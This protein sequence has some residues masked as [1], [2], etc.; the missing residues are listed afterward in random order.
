MRRYFIPPKRHTAVR[1]RAY[2]SGLIV[3]FLLLRPLISL[4]QMEV[5]RR[6]YREAESVY[7]TN[8]LRAADSY[9]KAQKAALQVG[10]VDYAISMS[11][12]LA[13]LYYEH[14]DDYPMAILEARRG[15]VWIARSGS[16]AD[17]TLFKLWA[18]LGEMYH[19][20]I[21]LDSTRYFWQQAE[22]I[23]A[24]H[25]ELEAQMHAHS[26]AYYGNMGTWAFEQGDYGLAE[27][28]FLKRLSL[29]NQDEEPERKAIAENQFASFYLK[30]GHWEEA[31]RLFEA[32]IVH[33][34]LPDLTRGWLLLGLADYYLQRQQPIGLIQNLR[35]IEQLPKRI[36]AGNPEFSSYVQIMW[37]GYCSLQQMYPKA[38]Q[39]YQKSIQSAKMVSLRGRLIARSYRLLSQAEAK[40]GAWPAALAHSQSAIIATSALFSERAIRQNPS[41]KDFLVGPALFEALYNKANL[42]TEYYHLT[43]KVTFLEIAIPT[44]QRAFEL[45]SLLQ[46]SYRTEF[47]K[48]FFQQQIRPAF[49]RG[50]SAAYQLYCLHSSQPNQRTLWQLQEWGKASVM[51]EIVKSRREEL[52][53]NIQQEE[54]QLKSQIATAKIR[55]LESRSSHERNQATRQRTTAELAYDRLCRR[56]NRPVISDIRSYMPQLAKLQKQLDNR[57]AYLHYSQID[58]GVL[59][60]IVRQDT[61]AFFRLA[62]PEQQLQQL[63]RDLRRLII[64]NPDPFPYRGSTL[65]QRLFANLVRPAWP[66]IQQTS[67]LIIVRDGPLHELP[68]E[69]LETGRTLADYLLNYAAI[70]YAYSA[71]SYLE[72][73][74]DSPPTSV[75]KL[76]G[77]AP[78]TLN[79]NTLSQVQQYQ[80]T[81]L[82]HS[83]EE[84]RAADGLLSTA[85]NATK[86]TFLELIRNHQVIH[87]ATHAEVN[88]EDADQSFIAF[89]PDSTSHKLYTHELGLLNLQHVRL[90]VL[91]ACESGNGPVHG[92]EGMLSLARAFRMAGCS[93]VITSLWTTHDASTAALMELFYANLR[94]GMPADMSLQKAKIQ[95]LADQRESGIWTPPHYWAHLILMDNNQPIFPQSDH[96]FWLLG[97]ILFIALVGLESIWHIKHRFLRSP[98]MPF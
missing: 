37:G 10:N 88:R 28:L 64:Q 94:D 55:W 56:I 81:V 62:I 17:S 57:S 87:L 80:Y 47:T 74:N 49:R 83:E 92:G 19:Q 71:Y 78:F 84:I 68:F 8:P 38:I 11:V 66:L 13:T 18:C 9:H 50:L 3:G 15:L 90:A 34:T 41:A 69:V 7:T 22:S 85:Q 27:R 63:T 16:C 73:L 4:A 21:R 79:A 59:L 12:N 29:I 70:S 86:Q 40:V 58:E 45:A 72:H 48:L 76:V 36:R 31:G 25:S 43:Q 89:F 26:S 46:S 75:P 91:T 97:L 1:L 77:M 65:S 96:R 14:Y 42:L 52:P 20:Q 93:A 39:W 98:L 95:F 32:S 2:W 54:S 61:V 44:Y 82:P 33:Y 60:T 30:T 24:K 51:Q 23:L 67:R 53:G 35:R 5:A 6:Y